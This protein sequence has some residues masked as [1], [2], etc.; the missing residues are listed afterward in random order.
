MEDNTLNPF[1]L[2]LSFEAVMKNKKANLELGTTLSDGVTS[3]YVIENPSKF[4]IS[5]SYLVDTVP[6][7]KVFVT[8][9]ARKYIAALSAQAKS[10]LWYILGILDYNKDTV[11]L[12][13]NK[14]MEE[15]NIKSRVTFYKVRDELVDAGFITRHKKAST[16]WINPFIMF[17]G[18][19]LKKYKDNVKIVKTNKEVN[20]GN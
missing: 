16:Y 3:D 17:H 7:V 20:E 13:T 18:D 9:A 14:Y 19:R 2:G 12:N 11:F 4:A 10:L 15:N 8:P 1:V 5:H 6:A